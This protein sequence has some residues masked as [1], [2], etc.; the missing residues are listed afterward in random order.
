[1]HDLDYFPHRVLLLGA[2]CVGCLRLR[3]NCCGHD[4]GC[5]TCAGPITQSSTPRGVA[6][7]SVHRSNTHPR[8]KHPYSICHPKHLKIQR[9]SSLTDIH[10]SS[11]LTPS[12]LRNC[13]A[14]DEAGVPVPVSARVRPAYEPLEAVPR[15]GMQTTQ[16]MIYPEATPYPIQ[17]SLTACQGHLQTP[18]TIMT[19]AL[20]P[21]IVASVT[22]V[23]VTP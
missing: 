3:T 21:P 18:P 7:G 13:A 4:Y 14:Y 8:S 9:S 5:P 6:S 2:K 17:T 23:M 19:R 11:A 12:P 10:S 20:H 15:L 16:S 22:S 1:M